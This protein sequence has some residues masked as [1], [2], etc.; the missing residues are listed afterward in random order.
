MSFRFPGITISE[1]Y[2]YVRTMKSPTLEPRNLS[3][4]LQQLF[5]LLILIS[6]S[7]IFSFIIYFQNVLWK[8]PHW[9]IWPCV[10]TV[11]D[12]P[13]IKFSLSAHIIMKLS[14]FMI[15]P[16]LL[17]FVIVPRYISSVNWFEYWLTT[18]NHF[19]SCKEQIRL[20]LNTIYGITSVNL[21]SWNK[22]WYTK[23]FC[24]L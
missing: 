8:G 18:K 9:P 23:L 21:H 13:A 7:S 10:W 20:L 17:F 12:Q 16:H 22:Q 15:P 24:R 1:I 3:T 6:W 14:S 5:F 11:F 2:L 19:R 4:A